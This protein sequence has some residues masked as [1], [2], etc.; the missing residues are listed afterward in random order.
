QGPGVDQSPAAQQRRVLI[1]AQ[2]LLDRAHFGPGVIDGKEGE[3]FRQALAA[4]ERARGMP[5]DGE[6][7]AQ[8]WQALTQDARP[9]MQ[10]YVITEEDA[11]G[12]YLDKLPPADDYK[13]LAALEK[14]SYTSPMEAIAERFHMDE[15]LLK[16]LNP[17]ADFA[18]AGTK[19]LVTAPTRAPLPQV[20]RIEVDKAARELRAYDASNSLVAI[21][22]ATVGSSDMPTPDGEWEVL[23][24]H[25]D[26][27][28]NY[29]PAKLNF[30][31]KSV[32]KLTIPAGP[33]NPVGLIWI[34]LSKDT[35]GI[36]G[37]PDPPQ[38][39]KTAS[40]GCVRL[41]NWDAQA[42]AA[43]VEKGVKVRFVSANSAT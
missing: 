24:V 23:S 12:P 27:V 25:E 36:H 10:D 38:V 32:G 7:D 35:Y 22:P 43:A 9:V 14:L 17:N 34:D 21:Y 33:N 29:D 42:L 18:K 28:W 16:A 2:V 1:K 11:R 5:A 8:V 20:A 19:I 4:Y 40:H 13:A 31:D 6:L 41:T 26:P 30:G 15:A 3:N 39:G 37:T